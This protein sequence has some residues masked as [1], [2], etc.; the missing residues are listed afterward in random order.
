MRGAIIESLDI[1]EPIAM[2]DAMLALNGT[3]IFGGIVCSIGVYKPQ[4]PARKLCENKSKEATLSNGCRRRL[5][6][7]RVHSAR[8]SW[9]DTRCHLL[10][11][12]V[13]YWDPPS[14]IRRRVE[15]SHAR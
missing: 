11:Q 5:V 8:A 6:V 9:A 7:L 12:I 2:L 1:F 14:Q 13:K 3:F 4:L 10:V 15:R